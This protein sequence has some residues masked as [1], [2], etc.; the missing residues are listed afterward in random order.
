MIVDRAL[1]T[2][3]YQQ[4]FEIKSYGKNNKERREALI[5]LYFKRFYL[6]LHLVLKNTQA[7]I[8]Q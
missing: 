5:Y 3:Q 4:L 2:F 6:T 1:K 8:R 7:K